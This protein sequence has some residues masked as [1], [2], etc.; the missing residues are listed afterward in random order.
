MVVTPGRALAA[1]GAAGTADGPRVG[2]VLSGGGARGLAHI[3]VLEV[4]ER[5]G[6]RVDCI[7]GTSMG[8]AVGA[9]WAS[10][11]P[12]A[13]IAEIVG[14]I[15]WQEVF[16]GHRLRP[17]IPLSRRLD[18]VPSALRIGLE[19]WK[20]RLP[21]SRDSDYRLNRLL[22]K[23][24]AAAGVG[25]GEDFDRLPV[26]FRAI[27]TD[28]ATGAPV[29]LARG[30]LARAVRASMSTPVT[31]PSV[32]LDGRTLVD[33]GLANNIPVSVAREM[34]ASVV[35]AVDAT[36]PP[37]RPEQY[38]DLYGVG[39]QIV[40]VLMRARNAE[41]AQPADLIVNPELGDHAFNDYSGVERLI[42]AG[43]RAAGQDAPRWRA[44]ASGHAPRSST[45]PSLRADVVGVEVRGQRHVDESTVRASFGVI[46][47]Q[48]FDMEGVLRGLDRV[49]ATGLFAAVW[50][51]ARPVEGGLR[52]VLEVTE[53][54]RLAAELGLSYDEA[55]RAAGFVRLRNRNAF[56][57]GERLDVQLLGGE[58]EAGARAALVGSVLGGS[59]LGYRLAGQLVK[60]RPVIYRDGDDAG[61]AE[62][63]RNVATA[64]VQFEV[65]PD[66][67]AQAGLAVGRI[68]SKFRP[69]LDLPVRADDYRMLTGLIA[70]DRLDDRDLPTSGVALALRG[71]RALR[72]LG[73]SVEYWRL[74]ADGRA[75]LGLSHGF[76]VEGSAL[77]GL[78]GRDVPI[79]D[80]YRLGGP[81]FRPGRPREEVWGRQVVALA[82]AP[83]CDW[84]GFRV[85]L[86]AGAGKVFDDRRDLS[87]R[88][89]RGGIGLGL[90]RRTPF[91]PVALEAGVD[92]EG[93]AAFYL[94]VGRW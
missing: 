3:G 42:A 5:E 51:D 6:L 25:A 34:G 10:G 72:S 9:L 37:L 93:H 88:G 48:P 45:A 54:P 59:D 24:L 83:A 18:D 33:G 30:S 80:W 67:L 82:V 85:S 89:L 14:S 43:R 87:L 84:R 73:A 68:D 38:R 36:S 19:G 44:L 64:A 49:W 46:P 32:S 26:P 7:A 11:Y 8:A 78:S 35:I 75:A 50:V 39:V 4:I 91:A 40:D 69:G 62:F 52:L 65:G 76:V 77:L 94:S 28:L 21:P 70:W 13:R 22:F 74:L 17:L 16:S 57:H 61:R 66:L 41:Y 27:A 20:L 31:L 2:L 47:R 58:R 90:A 53:A 79:Y 81:V 12:A 29:V 23:T 92:E 71:E 63:S 15:D 60:E 56:G 1:C 55:D 86:R